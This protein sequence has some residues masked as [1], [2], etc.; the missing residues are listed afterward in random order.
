ML[1]SQVRNSE[2]LNIEHKIFLTEQS[3]KSQLNVHVFRKTILLDNKKNN[4]I[5]CDMKYWL[6][7]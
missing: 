1:R 7:I 6:L 5:S 2:T 4:T 3:N